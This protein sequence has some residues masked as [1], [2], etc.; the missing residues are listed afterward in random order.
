LT[1]LS[2]R[3]I[4]VTF[5][6]GGRSVAVL[7]GVSLDLVPGELVVISGPSGSG[8]SVLLDVLA[9]WSQ[10]QSGTVSWQG[11]DQ[12]PGWARLGIVPQ[13]MGLMPDLSVW[14]NVT[15]PQRLARKVDRERTEQLL[16][17]LRLLHLVERSPEEL[18]LGEQQRVAVARATVLLPPLVL[19]DEPNAHQ[20]ADSSAAVLDALFSVCDNGGAVM[21]A[22]H[23][24]EVLRQADRVLH[25][26][27]GQLA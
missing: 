19:A 4:T 12:V 11:D 6:D 24:E 25:L 21:V 13:A 18:S 26:V 27:D 9:G 3:D 20:D 14:H 1:L 15:L 8:K 22:S 2:A 17:K 16:D 7:Q 23:D 10:P 5:N